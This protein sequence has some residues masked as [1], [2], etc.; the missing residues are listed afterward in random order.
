MAR[1]T[2]DRGSLEVALGVQKKTARAA[3]SLGGR[4][5]RSVSSSRA[6]LRVE[7]DGVGGGG[8]P[9]DWAA[10]MA[11]Q[12]VASGGQAASDPPALAHWRRHLGSKKTT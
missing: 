1:A 8:A 9:G 5:Q 12:R 11:R 4:R 2:A 10:S 7:E 3:G 6:A